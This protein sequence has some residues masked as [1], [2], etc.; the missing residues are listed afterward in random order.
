MTDNC[1]EE[2][3]ALT[4]TWPMCILLLCV[5]HVLQQL[6]KWLYEKNH[7]IAQPDRPYILGLFKK[8]LYSQTEKMFEELYSELLHDDTCVQYP[9]LLLYFQSLHEQK[10]AFA[11]CFRSQLPVRGNHTNNFMEAQFLVL[12]DIILKRTKEYN[13]VALIDKLT[14]DMEQHFKDKLL[15]IADGSFNG[16]YRRRFLGKGKDGAGGFKTPGEDEQHKILLSLQDF[17]NNVFRV[18]SSSQ[19]NKR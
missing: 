4:A 19:C 8:A 13:V 5:F 6:W 18:A 1:N 3:N 7:N 16:H 14:V 2:R 11:I 17:G 15:S 9:N 12:K 10:E